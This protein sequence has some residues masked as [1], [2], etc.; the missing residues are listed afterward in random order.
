MARGTPTRKSIFLALMP[1]ADRVKFPLQLTNSRAFY[2]LKGG[3]M[4]KKYTPAIFQ[5][6]IRP[7]WSGTLSYISNDELAEI[8][9]AIVKYPAVNL[10]STFWLETIKPDLD[11]QYENFKNV[12]ESRGRGARTYWGEH[13]L[14]IC[15]TDDKLVDNTSI[16]NNKLMDNI[17]KDKDKDKDKNKNKNKDKD[18]ISLDFV[19]DNFKPLFE[20]WLNY[21]K[22]KKQAY[23][24][25]ISAEQCYKHLLE[26]SNND[27]ATAEKIVNQAI[28]NNW[29][30][31]FPLK[32][33][34]GSKNGVDYNKQDA[35][36]SKYDRIAGHKVYG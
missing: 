25:I 4:T 15:S 3:T 20:K 6:T 34:G 14:S 30:G 12:C 19:A 28:G 18:K 2:F 32:E 11:E 22:E 1:P 31:L 23:K 5:P 16:T 7:S 9:K 36:T 13:K 26:L 10:T 24:G 8:F 21:K 29:A 33:K 27:L 17:L 35:D